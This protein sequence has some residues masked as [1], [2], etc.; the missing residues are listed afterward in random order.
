MY[1]QDHFARICR[2][3]CNHP[4]CV[5][6]GQYHPPGE[7]SFR[8]PNSGYGQ[9][10]TSPPSPEVEQAALN[11]Y[12]QTL[13]T[14]GQNLQ[15]QS[16]MANQLMSGLRPQGQM[17]FSPFPPVMENNSIFYPPNQNG[18]FNGQS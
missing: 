4:D 12:E 13:S 17:P 9:Q 7:C 8:Q 10:Y 15:S 2:L 16:M 14:V 6:H 11:F 3:K 5:K 18:W 1:G